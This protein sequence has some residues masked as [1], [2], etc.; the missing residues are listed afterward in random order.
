MK[1]ILSILGLFILFTMTQP[2]LAQDQVHKKNK[3][4]INCKVKEIG[5][6]EIKYSLPDYPPDLLFAIDKDNVDKVVFSN[7]KEMFFQH[8][9]SNPENYVDNKKNALKVD[10]L[11]PLTGNTTLFFEH[12]IRPGRSVEAGLGIIGLG[13]DPD[14]MNAFGAF[15][16]F[17]PKFIKSPDFYLRGMRYAH[18]LK[19]AYVKPEILFGYYARDFNQY[20]WDGYGDYY[21]TERKNVFTG[22]LLLNV[23]KQW[24]FDNSFL[25]DFHF[26]VG[27]GFDNIDEYY[28]EGYHFGFLMASDEVP[29]SFTAGLKIGGLLK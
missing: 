2:V 28:Y 24:V 3:E 15:V 23:G 20:Y 11:S 29:I 21:G 18:V 27:Y 26:G 5:T 17:A 1:T 10:F 8:E 12:S 14:D 4:I 19:G 7:G 6:D 13:I 22:A 25:V 16:R 9:L